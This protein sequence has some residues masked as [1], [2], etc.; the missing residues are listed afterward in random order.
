MKVHQENG[1]ETGYVSSMDSIFYNDPFEGE[2][3]LHEMLRGTAYNHILTVNPLLPC[4]DE[5]IRKGVDA[6]NIKG[7]RIYP[8]YH[9]Y[10]LDSPAV[11]RLCAVLRGYGL[12]LLLTIRI[13]DDRLN[14]LIQPR[15]INVP[16]ELLTF[17]ASVGDL[18]VL[19]MSL[20]FGELLYCRDD[21][22]QRKNLYVDTSGIKAPLE[23]VELL[24]REIGDEKIVYGSAYPIYALKSTLYEV[25]MSELPQ[26]SKER[27]LYQNARDFFSLT[28]AGR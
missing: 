21:L 25:T 1:I 9:N 19:I 16:D 18:P 27:I 11:A 22:L 3:D 8:C 26:Q 4:F 28:Q 7:V 5:D 12:P 24:V 13:E 10:Q 6:F 17:C 14:Y 23:S 20:S 2:L 15:R